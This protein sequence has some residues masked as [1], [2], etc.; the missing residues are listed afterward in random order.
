M[1]KRVLLAPA[2]RSPNREAIRAA[3]EEVAAE[4]ERMEAEKM[5]GQISASEATRKKE[6]TPSGTVSKKQPSA[7]R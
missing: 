4:R 3:V 1:K 6:K 5:A 2:V 7:R